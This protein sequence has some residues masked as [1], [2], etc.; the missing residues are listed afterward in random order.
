MIIFRHAFD[1]SQ[2]FH[3]QM[4]K[5]VASAFRGLVTFVALVLSLCK[6][7]FDSQQIPRAVV[8]QP[9]SIAARFSRAVSGDLSAAVRVH[10]GERSLVVLCLTPLS[11]HWDML[12]MDNIP[13]IARQLQDTGWSSDGPPA[14][15]ERLAPLRPLSVLAAARVPGLVN[16]AARVFPR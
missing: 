9:P 13:P 12:G 3:S 2:S 1:D 7:T 11:H 16:G 15:F 4:M 6:S 10:R 8:C 14:R 5:V